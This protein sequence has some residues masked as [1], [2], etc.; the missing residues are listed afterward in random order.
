VGFKKE[1]L[2][3]LEKKIIQKANPRPATDEIPIT[4]PKRPLLGRDWL[5]QKSCNPARKALKP[6]SDISPHVFSYFGGSKSST[7]SDMNLQ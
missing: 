7:Q 3:Y 5:S 6:A 4:I 1:R 2:V